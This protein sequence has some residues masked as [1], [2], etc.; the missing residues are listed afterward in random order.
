L[1]LITPTSGSVYLFG[2]DIKKFKAWSKIGYV[3]QKATHFDTNFPVTVKEV[4][5]MVR[6]TKN[7]HLLSKIK[8]EDEHI[9]EN[10]LREVEMWEH[11]NTLI[12]DLSGGQQQRVFIARALAGQPEIIFFDEPTVGVDKK[13]QDEFYTLIKQL[14]QKSHLTVVLISHD[15]ERITEEAMHIACVNKTLVCHTSAKEFFEESESLNIL[16]HK[17]KVIHHQHN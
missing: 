11:R 2:E 9:I 7:G 10:A 3:P 1:G 5:A 6:Y 4:V 16:G 17:V 15:I 12:G 8:D 14:N 13:T